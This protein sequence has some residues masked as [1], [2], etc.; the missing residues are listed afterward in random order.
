MDENQ[1]QA[2]AEKMYWYLRLT[3]ANI[4][5]SVPV[6]SLPAEAC[7]DGSWTIDVHLPME[8]PSL[9]MRSDSNDGGDGDYQYKWRRW[10]AA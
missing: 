9:Y 7:N 8:P 3:I 2:K 5:P 6:M 4:E 10:L 1:L